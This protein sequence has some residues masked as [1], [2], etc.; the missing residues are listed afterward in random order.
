MAHAAYGR[1]FRASPRL[2][3]ALII[4]ALA[5]A[6]FAVHDVG[7]ILSHPFWLDESWVADSLRAP[8]GRLPFLTSSTPL[9]FTLALRLV[10]AAVASQQARLVPL[11][12]CALAAAAG[13]ILGAELRINRYLTGLLVGTAVL[14]SPAMLVRDDLKQYT[15][16]GFASV[17]VLALAARLENEW[18]RRR[19]FDL[20]AF[21]VV[22]LLFA[23]T[24]LFVGAAVLGGFVL[25]TALKRQWRRCLET[26]VAGAATGVLCGV[27]YLFTIAPN[28]IPALKGYWAGDYLPH[29]GW[30]LALRRSVDKLAPYMG[31]HNLA[32][33]IPLALLGVLLLAVNGRFAM[34]I[35]V[36]VTVAA[37][38][39]ASLLQKYPFGDERTST[40]WLVMVSILMAIAVAYLADMAMRWRGAGAIAV[41]AAA[42]LVWVPATYPYIR[43]HN[44]P[45]EDL[46]YQVS[47]F[48]AHYRQG[49]VLIVDELGSFGF[50]FYDTRVQPQWVR[51]P[52]L[53]TG[54]LPEYPAVHWIVQTR[55]RTAGAV[56]AAVT[57]AVAKINAEAPTSR[58]RIWII[59]STET[60]AEA[61]G[62]ERALAGKEVEVIPGSGLPLLLYQPSA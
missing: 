40:F 42:L 16:E 6:V 27:I 47:Y 32:V 5:G 59:R 7:Y 52:P 61:T 11:V 35:S 54:F 4:S 55:A 17:A 49:D 10:P 38:V 14:L 46:R 41:V 57:A 25:E 39:V 51:F 56:T 60:N 58:G 8:I 18:T 2:I 24:D 62:W 36:P 12:F 53:A 29:R 15:A 3:D 44:I 37:N 20:C 19:L 9:G 21:I 22:I 1:R 13:Y 48:E 30:F 26:L 31:F 45:S 50:A 43:S 23:D 28:E 33:V 34:A